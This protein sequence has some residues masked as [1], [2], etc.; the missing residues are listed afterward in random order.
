MS[1]FRLSR[2]TR[3]SS[4]CKLVRFDT[5]DS[6]LANFA[7]DFNPLSAPIILLAEII[8]ID[9]AVLESF[10]LSMICTSAKRL[11]MS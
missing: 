6:C 9:R 10:P 11:G 4:I 7:E 1:T 3:V 2:E 5:S 8:A